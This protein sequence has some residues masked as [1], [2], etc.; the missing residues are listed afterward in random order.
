MPYHIFENE[1]KNIKLSKNIQ[2]SL[3]AQDIRLNALS[4]LSFTNEQPKPNYRNAS[5]LKQC[6]PLKIL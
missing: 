5:L 2:V 4:E 3:L 6:K 1:K